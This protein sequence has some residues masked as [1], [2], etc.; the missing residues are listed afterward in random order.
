MPYAITS[1]GFRAVGPEFTEADLKPDETLVAELPDY[2][3]VPTPQSLIAARR[4]VAEVR[5]ITVNGM[6][7]YTDRTTQNKLTAASVR[8]QR[9]SSYTVN[10]KLV[11]NTF[12]SLTAP[13][14]IAIG[15]AV[16]DYVQAC[17]DREAALLVALGNGTYTDAMLEEGWPA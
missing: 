13:Q 4:F 7:V 15:D 2:L 5:G 9:D 8:A 1:G 17:Y 3:L 12:I 10:W 6:S 16:G 11:D 14:L